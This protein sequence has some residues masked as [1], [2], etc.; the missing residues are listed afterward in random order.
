MLWTFSQPAVTAADKAID[1][2]C[3]NGDK[4]SNGGFC[5]G[6]KYSGALSPQPEMWAKWVAPSEFKDFS[7][8]TGFDA[9][10]NDKD[11]WRTKDTSFTV[12]WTAN[13]WLPKEQRSTDYYVNEYRFTAGQSVT[14]YTYVYGTVDKTGH[15]LDVG[16]QAVTLESGLSGVSF[17]AAILV[18]SCTMLLF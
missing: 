10:V 18:S 11:N 2:V 3:I 5:C 1:A 7:A 4:Y 12:T 17:V 14:T 15:K 6:I 8:S 9:S 13:R 16:K